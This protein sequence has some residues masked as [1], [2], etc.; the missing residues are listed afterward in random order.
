MWNVTIILGYMSLTT[1]VNDILM[2]CTNGNPFFYCFLKVVLTDKGDIIQIIKYLHKYK[3]IQRGS[4]KYLRIPKHWL[5]PVGSVSAICDL[6]KVIS[7]EVNLLRLSV[8]YR[9]CRPIACV[10][11]TTHTLWHIGFCPLILSLSQSSSGLYGWLSR[12]SL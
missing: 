1:Y 4:G 10:S 9:R 5:L 3:M 7:A 2:F 8:N 11:P 12:T 6:R